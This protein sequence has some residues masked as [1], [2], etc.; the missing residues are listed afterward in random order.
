MVDKRKI[1]ITTYIIMG[2]PLGNSVKQELKD[3]IDEVLMR[4]GVGHE[5]P[6]IEDKEV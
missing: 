3:A 4:W 1:V 2:E 5:Q 6:S